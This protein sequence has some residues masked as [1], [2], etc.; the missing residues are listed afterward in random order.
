MNPSEIKILVVDDDPDILTGT[1]HLLRQS[2]YVVTG[3]SNGLEALQ[4]LPSFRP[5]LV[6]SDRDMPKMDGRAVIME[7]KLNEA[8]RI[9]PI[10][11]LTATSDLFNREFTIELG[12]ADYVT[13]PVEPNVLLKKIQDLLA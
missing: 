1:A 12:A 3:A 6:L 13:K 8:T 5:Q 10:L 4:V 7:L 2:G 9:I 11:I